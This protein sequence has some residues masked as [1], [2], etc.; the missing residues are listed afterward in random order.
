MGCAKGDDANGATAEGGGSVF[1]RK[2]RPIAEWRRS[3][4]TVAQSGIPAAARAPLFAGLLGLRFWGSHGVALPGIVV[5]ATTC[6]AR[7]MIIPILHQR[8]QRGFVQPFLNISKTS[9]MKW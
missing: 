3:N 2:M 1:R 8:A 9:R 4:S 7:L 6:I 5:P